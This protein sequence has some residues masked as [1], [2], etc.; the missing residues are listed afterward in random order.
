MPMLVK[1]DTGHQNQIDTPFIGLRL[2]LRNTETPLTHHLFA[3]IRTHLHRVAMGNRQQECFLTFKHSEQRTQVHLIMNR[4]IQE[5]RLRFAKSG[6][7]HQ[8]RDD[9]R[10]LLLHLL[11]SHHTALLLYDSPKGRLLA[12]NAIPGKPHANIVQLRLK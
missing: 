10:R 8:L 1:N 6:H 11:G 5:Y 4:V 2:R 7:L 12:T 9:Q 3:V